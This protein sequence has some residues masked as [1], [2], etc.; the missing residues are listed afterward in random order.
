MWSNCPATDGS[1]A[2]VLC[3]G[4]PIKYKPRAGSGLTYKWLM[5]HVV[6]S[7]KAHYSDPSNKIAEVL[8]MPVLWC[9]F[10]SGLEHMLSP[11]VR[12]RIRTAYELIR[13]EDFHADWN[14]VDKVPLIVTVGSTSYV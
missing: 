3:V 14:P 1:V 4:G 2:A 11:E 12:S 9:E 5:T 6:P 10:Q 8:A 7:I 13:P